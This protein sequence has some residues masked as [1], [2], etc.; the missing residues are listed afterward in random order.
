MHFSLYPDDSFTFLPL[1][2]YVKGFISFSSLPHRLSDLRTPLEIDVL[3]CL[4]TCVCV[5]GQRFFIVSSD[6]RKGTPHWFPIYPEWKIAI[7]SIKSGSGFLFDA[8]LKM[9]WCSKLYLYLPICNL[10]CCL[11]HQDHKFL[12]PVLDNLWIQT[13]KTAGI[14]NHDI[15]FQQRT[16][17]CGEENVVVFKVSFINL[18]NATECGKFHMVSQDFLIV[19]STPH[20]SLTAWHFYMMCLTF[21]ST[22]LPSFI[23]L[24]LSD[25]VYNSHLLGQG[26]TGDKQKLFLWQTFLQIS[27]LARSWNPFTLFQGFSHHGWLFLSALFCLPPPLLCT[28]SSAPPER[29]LIYQ[30]LTQMSHKKLAV[31]TFVWFLN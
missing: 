8:S 6:A 20:F 14:L 5:L 30:I 4:D 22:T 26:E 1:L 10:K 3:R 23:S 21:P 18:L 29:S 24:S 27:S 17:L 15:V 31:E 16:L 28:A 9:P 19:P 13:R 12:M 2:S 7:T 11:L 25:Y